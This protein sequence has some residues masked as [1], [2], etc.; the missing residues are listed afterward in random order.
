MIMAQKLPPKSSWIY[1]NQR[2]PLPVFY[3]RRL[4]EA[5]RIVRMPIPLPLEGAHIY[6]RGN[7]R[8]KGARSTVICKDD[9]ILFLES[10]ASQK[11]MFEVF[12][13]LCTVDHVTEKDVV[14]D[15]VDFMTF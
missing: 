2:D 15:I 11:N 3:R 14:V 12:G 13:V 6:P 5:A 7:S 10:R 8:R 9:D 1:T 4:F